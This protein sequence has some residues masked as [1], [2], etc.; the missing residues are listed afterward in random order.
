MNQ[1]KILLKDYLKDKERI[2]EFILILWKI[3]NYPKN[4]F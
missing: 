1:I 4:L 2:Y 3:I